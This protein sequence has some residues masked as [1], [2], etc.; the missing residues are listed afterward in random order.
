MSHCGWR[1]SCSR[2]WR[3]TAGVLVRGVENEVGPHQV[4]TRSRN[5]DTGPTLANGQCA[6]Q[7]PVSRRGAGLAPALNRLIIRRSWVQAPP[8]P[9]EVVVGVE[10]T[11]AVG[12]PDRTPLRMQGLAD[13]P[14]GKG[15]ERPQEAAAADGPDPDDHEGDHHVPEQVGHQAR[16]V[17]RPGDGRAPQGVLDA[18]AVPV[19]LL[20][21]TAA[22]LRSA[23]A[24]ELLRRGL[25]ARL[26]ALPPGTIG[27]GRGPLAL[28][29]SAPG[30]G[31][32]ATVPSA[33]PSRRARAAHV[34]E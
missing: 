26:R 28:P 27:G 8:A 9:Q 29:F 19:L 15:V 1:S 22:G 33:R 4:R 23:P 34:E 13:A 16:H 6:G 12:A 30:P 2:R 7:R 21:W 11:A 25:V 32:W 24:Q 31:A 5:S 18:L 10:P 17:L 20:R 3:P 14:T